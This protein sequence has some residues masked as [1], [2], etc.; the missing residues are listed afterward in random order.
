VFDQ[1]FPVRKTMLFSRRVRKL[2]GTFLA[3]NP[4][5]ALAAGLILFATELSGATPWSRGSQES[6]P[7]FEVLPLLRSRQNHLIVRAS[8]NGKPALLTV[9]T[10]APV[11]VIALK[12]RHHFHLSGVPE[13]S[14]L[15]TSLQINNAVNRVAIA[16]SFCLGALEVIDKPVVVADLDSSS[17]AA[18][19]EHEQESDG[20]LGA[21]VLFP[22]KAVLDCKKQTLILKIDPSGHG[23]APGVSYR[24][25]RKMRIRVG[26][27]NLYVDAAINGSPARLMIDTGSFFTIL[28]HDYVRR[29][30]IPLRKTQFRSAGVNLEQHR[31]ELARIRRFSVGSVN[32]A[33]KV[34]A[35]VDLEGLFHSDLLR[36]KPPVAGLLGAELLRSHHGIIDF[37]TR[38]L[39][40]QN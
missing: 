30:R 28:H 35:V 23:R 6:L 1:F 37:G 38:T 24:G 18:H 10:G 17:Q 9:D 13:G 29:M 25:F 16:H 34:V 40:L 19:M 11:S 7:Q 8:I 31:I 12:R 26:D 20:F 36:G 15:A 14:Q 2:N 32:I 21:D 22:T 27:G 3:R 4:L 39:Y 5:W 33:G